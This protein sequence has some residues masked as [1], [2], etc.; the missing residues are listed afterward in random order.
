MRTV[1]LQTNDHGELMALLFPPGK[2]YAE[3]RR[4]QAAWTPRAGE[5]SI[6][7]AHR[8]T[9][10]K[11]AEYVIEHNLEGELEAV[12]NSLL[13]E[14][15]ETKWYAKRF[16]DGASRFDSTATRAQYASAVK[17]KANT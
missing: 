5:V 15:F 14:L 12:P 13:D 10:L 17:I 16:E 11:V 1:V 3:I 7:R 8:P 9:A 2:R 6:E 4:T